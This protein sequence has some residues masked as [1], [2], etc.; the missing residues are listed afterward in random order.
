VR[1]VAPRH[2][3]RAIATSTSPP[4]VDQ[5]PEIGARGR[6][7]R[8]VRK[9]TKHHSWWDFKTGLD[10]SQPRQGSSDK[11]VTLTM[12]WSTAGGWLGTQDRPLAAVNGQ[13]MAGP[14]RAQDF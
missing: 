11:W 10:G 3:P 2:D 4:S 14:G 12:A 1:G 9:G 6:R 8:K 7:G 5:T 13:F